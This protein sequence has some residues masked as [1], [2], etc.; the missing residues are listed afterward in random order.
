[1]WERGICRRISEVNEDEKITKGK[2]K[3]R[4]KIEEK[5]RW[6]TSKEHFKELSHIKLHN[7]AAALPAAF[8][9]P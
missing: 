9:L 4:Q 1:L 7:L 5:K 3:E 8:L 2:K 6:R